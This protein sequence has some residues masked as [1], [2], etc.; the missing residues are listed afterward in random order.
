MPT[1]FARNLLALA[2]ISV[3]VSAM[4]QEQRLNELVIIGDE[5][6]ASELPG[7]AHVVSNEKLEEMKYTD[8]QRALR[9]VPG[10]YIQEEEGYGLPEYWYSW[11][12]SRS[13]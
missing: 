2:V 10:I 11:F 1:R 6:S 12:R 13:Q 4:A 5:A 9:Q 7:S 8:V 3:S